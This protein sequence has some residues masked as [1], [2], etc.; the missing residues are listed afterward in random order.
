MIDVFNR[1]KDRSAAT[2]PES[3]IPESAI[4][5]G[6]ADEEAFSAFLRDKTTFRN[7]PG[8]IPTG[9]PRRYN[10][11]VADAF[12]CAVALDDDQTPL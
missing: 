8:A 2:I 1:T 6:A 4:P 5:E 3:A 10:K 7:L 11:G 12:D 9:T